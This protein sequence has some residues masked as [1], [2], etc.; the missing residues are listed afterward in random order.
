VWAFENPATGLLKTR[1]V[2]AGVPYKDVS[3]CMYGYPYRKPTRIW[4]NSVQWEP[5]PMCRKKAPC[6]AVVDGYHPM[7]AQRGP[8]KSR[9]R[10]M[11]K[12]DRCSQ[13]QL[14]SM[15]AA[16]CQELATA[17]SQEVFFSL[18]KVKG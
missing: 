4:T 5:R 13:R 8:S 18:A 9:V 2:V 3:Y 15:P 7:T 17:F 10:E 1:A 6:P 14:Y 16:L 11:N 12:A